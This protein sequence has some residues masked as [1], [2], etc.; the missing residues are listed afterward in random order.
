MDYFVSTDMQIAGVTRTIAESLEGYEREVFQKTVFPSFSK[1]SKNKEEFLGYLVKLKQNLNR[2]KGLERA[3]LKTMNVP[4]LKPARIKFVSYDTV[5]EFSIDEDLARE[6]IYE[7]A[8][9][10]RENSP[11][12]IL[13]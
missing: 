1:I 10:A 8:I 5:N 13:Y 3:V 6:G 12:P 7:N 9:K 11:V 2:A 4:E